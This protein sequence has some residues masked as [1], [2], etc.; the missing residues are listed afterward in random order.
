MKLGI[1]GPDGT[2]C[3]DDLNPQSYKAMKKIF[4]TLCKKLEPTE[5]ITIAEPWAYY[6][7]VEVA[8]ELNVPIKVL[9]STSLEMLPMRGSFLV[10]FSTSSREGE[11]L[12]R[13][14]SEFRKLTD[15]P[16]TTLLHTTGIQFVQFML[17]LQYMRMCDVMV[18]YPTM[19]Q[20]GMS[21]IRDWKKTKHFIPRKFIDTIP[22][23]TPDE[24]WIKYQTIHNLTKEQFFKMRT[25]GL[26]TNKLFQGITDGKSRSDDNDEA[27]GANTL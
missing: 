13:R 10:K 17:P 7:P 26:I 2:T 24:E 9:S 23:D 14:H 20:F 16:G 11:D 3:V 19:S 6:I 15:V 18:V 12:N 27:Q 5:L 8:Q 22:I 25:D 1:I 4:L 21:L